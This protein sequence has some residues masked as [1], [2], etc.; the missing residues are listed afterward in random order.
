MDK[1]GLVA[2]LAGPSCSP[3]GLVAGQS[4]C[5][6]IAGIEHLTEIIL[7]RISA[8]VRADLRGLQI[9]LLGM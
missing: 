3:N 4:T 2:Q 6:G 5:P 7:A 1:E 9:L 8:R